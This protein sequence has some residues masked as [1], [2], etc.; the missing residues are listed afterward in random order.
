VGNGGGVGNGEGVGDGEGMGDGEGVGD[1]E[2]V[3]VS[4]AVPLATSSCTSPGV[5][6]PCLRRLTTRPKLSILIE[7]K[8]FSA[9]FLGFFALASFVCLAGVFSPAPCAFVGFFMAAPARVATNRC[10]IN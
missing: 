9:G 3:T 7:F 8:S 4:L 2:G 10:C 5:A 1:S 6:R